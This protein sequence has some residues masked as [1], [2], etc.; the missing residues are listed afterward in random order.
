MV[1]CYYNPYL[2]RPYSRNPSMKMQNLWAGNINRI[3][4]Y[5]KF[6][7]EG[8]YDQ[9]ELNRILETAIEEFRKCLKPDFSGKKDLLPTPELFRYLHEYK[10][11]DYK[12]GGILIVG[13]NP[14]AEFNEDLEEDPAKVDKWKKDYKIEDKR[15]TSCCLLNNYPYF[16]TFT[17]RDTLN[18]KEVDKV[19]EVDEDE[20]CKT[21][22]GVMNLRE[23]DKDIKF[24]DIVLIRSQSKKKLLDYVNC[25]VKD[26]EAPLENVIEI[27][28]E[29]FLEKV[30]TI[31]EPK[32]VV[33]NSTNLSSF[34]ENRFCREPEQNLKGTT[35]LKVGNKTFPCVLSG[36]ISGQR[37][38]DKWILLRMKR[39]IVEVYRK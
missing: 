12:K 29:H 2:R 31:V 35:V 20:K 7:T 10:E 21:G 22:K 23:V 28:C 24:T 30:L 26:G 11:Y 1:A 6:M 36:Q 25:K 8:E 16:K 19:S 17:G 37:A 39:A 3:F 15:N 4:T 9:S 5:C 38:M 33:C 34:L 32:V 27:G 14:H 13:L 18:S